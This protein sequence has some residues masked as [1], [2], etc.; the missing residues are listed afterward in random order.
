MNLNIYV[1]FAFKCLWVSLDFCTFHL[2]V[3]NN[4]NV[5]DA[6]VMDANEFRAI[7]SNILVFSCQLFEKYASLL[8]KILCEHLK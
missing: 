2:P 8:G 6:Q 4:I 7:H 5:A 1:T 3:I